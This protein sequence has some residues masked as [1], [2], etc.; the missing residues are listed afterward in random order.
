MMEKKCLLFGY[1]GDDV[2]EY[3]LST[4]F[5]IST[6]T[7]VGSFDVAH[8]IHGPGGLAFNNDGT[9]MFVGGSGRAMILM[10]THYH[11]F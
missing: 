1:T 3:T 7:F 9:K 2:N 10:N 11:S 5:D 8:K 6:A 4:G